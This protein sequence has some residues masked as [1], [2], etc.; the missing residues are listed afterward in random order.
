[1][2]TRFFTLLASLAFHA[3]AYAMPSTV[4]TSELSIANIRL[5]QN[6][7]TTIRRL[8]KPIS[9]TNDG[10][11]FVLS[12]VG[13]T[14]TLGVGKYGVYE[15]ESTS[16]KYCTPRMACPGMKL[17]RLKR[18]YGTP[19][20]ANRNEGQFHEYSARDIPCWLQ[21]SVIKDVVKTIRVAC[22]P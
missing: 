16:P 6:E 10:D 5:G 2:N 21:V 18:L 19:L 8:G 22:Q 9:R 15:M 14:I 4:P 3:V 12:Y 20:L 17:S 7:R 1:M 13:L 11:G